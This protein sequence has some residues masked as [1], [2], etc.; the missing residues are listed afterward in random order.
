MHL[1]LPRWLGGCGCIVARQPHYFSLRV[2]IASMLNFLV[3]RSVCHCIG[4][5]SALAEKQLYLNGLCG[6]WIAGEQFQLFKAAIPG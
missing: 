3:D 2:V 5:S 1:V 4:K 6:K